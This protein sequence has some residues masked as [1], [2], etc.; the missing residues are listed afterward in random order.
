MGLTAFTV[1]E[2]GKRRPATVVG[3]PTDPLQ[4]ILVMD[5]S[6]SMAGEKLEMSKVAAI[7]AVKSAVSTGHPIRGFEVDDACRNHIRAA[8][9]VEDF[10]HR[11]G[12]SI[13]EEVHGTG[14]NMDNLET[15]DERRILP[16]SLFSVEPG[17]YYS[18][19]GVRTEIDM[20]VSATDAI[21]TGQM[22]TK[23]LRSEERRVG[24]ECRSRWSPY[25]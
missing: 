4:L 1:L 7:A 5:T 25:H 22:Q 19:Y 8:G 3:L 2:T 13:G 10:V 12:H 17:L 9:E 16:G 15:H 21:V 11:T 14:A 23:L 20:Y 24:K 6:G 18:D